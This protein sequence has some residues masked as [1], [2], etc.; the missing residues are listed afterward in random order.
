M[1]RG[2]RHPNGCRFLVTTILTITVIIV[3]YLWIEALTVYP[4]NLYGIL[5]YRR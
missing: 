2:K 3:L 4:E 1:G 5:N